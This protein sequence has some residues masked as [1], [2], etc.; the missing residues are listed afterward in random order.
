[1]TPFSP[2]DVYGNVEL[3]H[4]D[5]I[6]AVNNLLCG[7]D[8][9]SININQSEITKECLKISSELTEKSIRENF[10]F[11]YMPNVYRGK[12]WKVVIDKPAYNESY[13]TNYTFSRT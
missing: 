11:Y 13:E 5:F 2:Q 10:Y 8:G 9:N 7:I 4:P 6:K 1:M 3:L 12:N